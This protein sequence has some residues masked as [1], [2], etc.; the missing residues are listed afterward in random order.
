LVFEV[1]FAKMRWFGLVTALNWMMAII[2]IALIV[3]L[4]VH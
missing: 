1:D 4:V 2:A 3:S